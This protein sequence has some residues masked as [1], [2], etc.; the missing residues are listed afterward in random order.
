MTIQ[1][2]LAPATVLLADPPWKFR[3]ALPGNGRGASKHYACMDIDAICKYELPPLA[4]DCVLILWRVSS[5]V[6]EAYRVVRSWG[7]TPKSEIVWVKTRSD[8][9]PE[10][11]DGTADIKM[12][13]GMGWIVR[14]VHETA[15]VATRGRVKPTVRNIPTVFFAPRSKHSAKPLKF[16]DIIGK[17]FSS[18][19]IGSKRELFARSHQPGWIS[20]GLELAQRPDNSDFDLLFDE[21]AATQPTITSMDLDL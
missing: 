19:P 13:I 20:T 6:E 21:P 17:L 18:G 12:Q 7:F 5:M 3:D 10:D 14:G 2:N 9:D 1:D 8:N 4:D 11:P 16:Y 15:I